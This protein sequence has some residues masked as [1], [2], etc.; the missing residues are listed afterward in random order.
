[1]GNYEKR[2]RECVKNELINE[3]IKIGKEGEYER[4]TEKRKERN[5]EKI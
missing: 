3:Q 5:K 2:H 1:M 4:A